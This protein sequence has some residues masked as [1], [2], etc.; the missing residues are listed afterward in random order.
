VP[1]TSTN[2]L[3]TGRRTEAVPWRG[4]LRMSCVRS[5]KPPDKTCS[6]DAIRK[7]PGRVWD[8][9]GRWGPG[10]GS[11]VQDRFPSVSLGPARQERDQS[12]RRRQSRRQNSHGRRTSA[13]FPCRQRRSGRAP[14][15]SAGPAPHAPT[16][17]T[18]RTCG[19]PGI[20]NRAGWPM[21]RRFIQLSSQP[22][23]SNPSCPLPLRTRLIRAPRPPRMGGSDETKAT[24][25]ERSF[26]G[27]DVTRTP[28]LH[29]A[30]ARS[31]TKASPRNTIKMVPALSAE[32][33]KRLVDTARGKVVAGDKAGWRST[34]L[35]VMRLM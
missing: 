31:D 34:T 21:G 28:A 17:L 11:G 35:P 18:H 23:L 19:R 33:L 24:P 13:L 22:H 27:S 32:Y 30:R 5:A 8:R 20:A 15:R 14:P 9:F 2:P 25:G 4:S 16:T 29:A 26:Q 1:S 6:T 12:C 3:A 10:R 7:R